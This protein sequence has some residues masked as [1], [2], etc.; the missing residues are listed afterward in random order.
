ML[1]MA[2]KSARA[3]TISVHFALMLHALTGKVAYTISH[4]SKRG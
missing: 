2:V 4:C 1:Y 3:H